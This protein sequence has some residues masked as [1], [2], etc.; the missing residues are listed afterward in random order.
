MPLVICISLG[1]NQGSHTGNTPLEE[2]LSSALLLGGTYV[3][4]GT[5]NEAGMSHHYYGKLNRAAESAELELLIRDA[6]KGVTLEFWAEPLELYDIGFTSPL[7]ESIQ[8]TY[9][10]PFSYREFTF[11]LENT[12]IY[13]YYSA[14]ELS[15]GQQVIQIR[16]EHPS[17]GIW[18]LHVVNRSYI[19]GSFHLWLPIT[20]LS[21]PGTFFTAPNPDTCLLYTSC[22]RKKIYLTQY[23][24]NGKMNRNQFGTENVRK[25]RVNKRRCFMEKIKM[26][27]P[28]VEMDGD[29]MTRVLWKIIKEE[30]IYPYIDLKSEYYDLG[31]EHRNETNDQVTICLL[32]TSSGNGTDER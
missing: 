11:A 32:Y 3:V 25:N 16:I 15:T 21:S 23:R 17:T 29:E 28:L 5:G 12:K 26:T 7:G 2:V 9:Y 13:V 1:S 22:G 30:L 27:T 18:R 6:S 20:G 4:A 14:L 8:P 19:N 24:E 10:G 31:L